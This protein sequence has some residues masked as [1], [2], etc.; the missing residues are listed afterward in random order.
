AKV[1]RTKLRVVRTT[2]FHLSGIWP[3]KPKS[4]ERLLIS[5]ERLFSYSEIL[6]HRQFL[7]ERAWMPFEQLTNWR[8]VVRTTPYFVRTSL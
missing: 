2:Q 1:V 7:F 5:F 8:K 6:T 3:K 4:F